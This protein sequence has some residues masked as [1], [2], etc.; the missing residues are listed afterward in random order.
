MVDNHINDPENDKHL[1]IPMFLGYKVLRPSGEESKDLT[2]KI[3]KA[4][5]N[6]FFISI[7]K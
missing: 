1:D 3:H 6:V 2:T 5:F 7:D 4:S